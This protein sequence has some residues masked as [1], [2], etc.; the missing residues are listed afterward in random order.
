MIFNLQVTSNDQ[1]ANVVK[2]LIN[3]WIESHSGRLNVN[4]NQV[5]VFQ[6]FRIPKYLMSKKIDKYSWNFLWNN[7]KWLMIT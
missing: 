1:R 6:T 4:I 2:A 5:A 7:K 3:I